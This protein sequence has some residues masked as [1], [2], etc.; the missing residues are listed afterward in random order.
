MRQHLALDVDDFE[1]VYR[2]AKARGVLEHETFYNCMYEVPD[3]AVQIY[4]RD[5]AGHLIEVD[6][7][8][9]TTLDRSA[10]PERKKL[11][12]RVPQT[13]EALAAT[14]YLDRQK[15]GAPGS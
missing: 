6:W 1:A 7:P 4:L 8:D 13:G 9:V 10:F 11:S 5:P 3:G 12:D 2:T 14:L 15:S